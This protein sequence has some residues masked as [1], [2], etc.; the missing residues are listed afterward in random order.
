VLFLKSYNTGFFFKGKKKMRAAVCRAFGEPLQ[1]EEV[2]IAEPGPGEVHIRL[3]AVAICHS[4]IVLL[5]GGWGGDLPAVYGHEAAGVVQGVGAGVS[6]IAVGDHVVVTLI[7]SCGQCHHCSHKR[8]TQCDVSFSLDDSSPL[9]DGAGESLQQGLRTGAFAEEV[10]V[11]QSQVSVIPEDIPLDA[12]ALLACGVLTGF[13]AVSNTAAIEPSSSVAVIGCGGVGVN[14]IQGAVHRAAE[15]VIAMDVLNSKLQI[16]KTFGA[17]HTVNSQALDCV[18]QVMEITD[19]RGVDYAFVTVGAKSAI[20]LSLSVLAR[21]GTSV[22]VGMPPS[23]IFGEFDPGTLAALGQR[24]VGSKMGSATV[25]VDIPKLAQLYQNGF[26]KLDELISGR[27]AL[28]EIN[29]AVSSMRAGAA[30]RNVVVFT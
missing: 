24:I 11:E 29:E 17:S 4:D 13:G 10:V 28:E 19:G 20:D 26:L 27:Y 22:I 7:R 6:T 23:G 21:G 5:D 1:I 30:L 16:A 25:K 18:Q 3:A 8:E 14:S 9:T 2:A 12:A 15:T